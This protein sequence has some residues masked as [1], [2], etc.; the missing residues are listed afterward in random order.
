MLILAPKPEMFLQW[1]SIVYSSC[2]GEGQEAPPLDDATNKKPVMA[3]KDGAPAAKKTGY[4][5]NANVPVAKKT[6]STQNSMAPVAKETCDF[7]PAKA[8]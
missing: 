5:K 4:S 3:E 1:H 7:Y 2:K 6:G 8:S